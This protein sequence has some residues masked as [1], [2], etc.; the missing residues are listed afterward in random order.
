MLAV[1][2][3]EVEHRILEVRQVV[4]LHVLDFGD[5]RRRELDQVVLL[6]EC[7]QDGERT[8]EVRRDECR[9]IARHDFLF[10][11]I[12]ELRF[13]V[14]DG[15]EAEV[16]AHRPRHGRERC[17]PVFQRQPHGAQPGPRKGMAD[18]CP[19]RSRSVVEAPGQRAIFWRRQAGE[20]HRHKPE[21]GIVGEDG[22]FV[23]DGPIECERRYFFPRRAA[24]RLHFV[25]GG[26]G[27][28]HGPEEWDIG[29]EHR[30][31]GERSA[32]D[33]EAREHRRAA[34]VAL[35]VGIVVV[36]HMHAGSEVDAALG[37]SLRPVIP[38]VRARPLHDLLAVDQHEGGIDGNGRE[39]EML[40]FVR[41]KPTLQVQEKIC[42]R[43][44][45]VPALEDVSHHRA[46]FHRRAFL[47]R[48]EHVLELR[49]D[50]AVAKARL[51]PGAR[52]GVRQMQRRPVRGE[53]DA[54]ASRVGGGIEQEN[55]WLA[56]RGPQHIGADCDAGVGEDAD[57]Q[58]LPADVRHEELH[59]RHDRMPAVVPGRD[60]EARGRGGDGPIRRHGHA[61]VGRVGL[62]HGRGYQRE[63][64]N[65]GQPA[66]MSV[67]GEVAGSSPSQ[68]G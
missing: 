10:Q 28:H 38:I 24:C 4:V 39:V 43:A 11:G 8:G 44:K 6:V 19:V 32:P 51:Q 37:R 67:H 57:R 45:T 29:R 1:I 20:L 7:A 25:T 58:A 40:R 9:R 48:I 35:N 36:D 41:G 15:R 52:M 56:R 42:L 47:P 23:G 17:V 63:D 3:D 26:I 18:L 33:A 21:I 22:G 50:A 53:V 14:K 27:K 66:A 34:T 46:P 12:V 49:D 16:D 13:L 54:V 55:E 64:E 59:L 68:R 31:V 62:R 5:H 60:D 2:M 30:P 65:A 61:G